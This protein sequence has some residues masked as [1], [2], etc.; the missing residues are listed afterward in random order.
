MSFIRCSENKY[1]LNRFNVYNSSKG[2]V[3]I[4]GYDGTNLSCYD[5]ETHNEKSITFEELHINKIYYRYAGI[6]Y[7]LDTA[8]IYKTSD[9][10]EVV[11]KAYEGNVLLCVDTTNDEDLSLNVNNIIF[12]ESEKEK[13][14]PYLTYK[15]KRIDIRPNQ[16]LVT[17]EEKVE[18]ISYD[19]SLN[20]VKCDN[21]KLYDPFEE[22]IGF[23][24]FA[25]DYVKGKKNFEKGPK[26]YVRKSDDD[27]EEIPAL[28]TKEFKFTS[29]LVNGTKKKGKIVGNNHN[30][31]QLNFKCEEDDED[32]FVNLDDLSNCDDIK[33]NAMIFYERRK[34]NL[35]YEAKTSNNSSTINENNYEKSSTSSTKSNH[36]EYDFNSLSSSN[37]S[38]Q[39]DYYQMNN[40]S[41]DIA[42]IDRDISKKKSDISEL[43]VKRI[44]IFE[45]SNGSNINYEKVTEINRDI[46][47]LYYEIYVLELDKIKKMN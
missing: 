20:K 5:A 34:S 30:F 44:E 47:Y 11:V 28:V 1:C 31:S 23:K 21:G 19:K 29:A 3:Y 24:E 17:T 13:I 12:E 2:R 6:V 43:N 10:K 4:T 15:G 32:V 40:Y 38:N 7:K 16:K 18:V 25:D 14:K 36:I 8:K 26:V 46:A 35:K 41:L 37:Y 42:K 27:P 45:K 39:M 22:F 33:K 9:N